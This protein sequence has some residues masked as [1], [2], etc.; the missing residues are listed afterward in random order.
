MATFMST[1]T[2]CARLGVAPDGAGDALEGAPGARDERAVR[3]DDLAR[4]RTRN[5][6]L[7]EHRRVCGRCL[8]C[9]RLFWRRNRRRVARAVLRCARC[10]ARPGNCC[11]VVAESVTGYGALREPIPQQAHER[12]ASS[13]QVEAAG[14]KEA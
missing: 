10:C 4:P 9:V 5:V 8:D 13:S 3:G 1:G 12:E 6:H 2:E 14:E 7:L 11:K